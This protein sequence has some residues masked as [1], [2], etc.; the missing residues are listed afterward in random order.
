MNVPGY[1]ASTPLGLV[2]GV[3]WFRREIYLPAKIAGKRAML[4]LGRIVDA[5]SVF[6]NGTFVGTTG[7]QYP[8]RRYNIP[9]NLLKESKNTISV[10]IISNSGVGGFVPDKLYAIVCE[11]DTV[12]LAGKWQYKLGAEMEPLGGQTFVRWKPVGLYNA[13]IAPLLNFNIKGVLWYQGESNA[14]KPLEYRKL[15]PTLITDW[16]TH[17][18]QGNFPFIIVQL[19]NF[20]E[21]KNLPAESNWALFRESQLKALSVSNTGLVVAIDLGEWND[22]HPLK[23]KD[24]G[25]RLALQTE[26]LACGDKKVVSSGPIYSSMKVSGNRIVLTFNSIGSGLVAK[27]GDKLKYFAIAGP[28]KK[29]VWA[30]AE[31]QQDKVIVWSNE[32]S[33]PVAERYAWADDPDGANLY[34]KDGLPSSPFRTDEW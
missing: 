9:K 13:M 10:R 29:F 6:I 3:V 31:I 5:D 19:P 2:N 7:Y 34:N 16:R 26:K 20:M 4:I 11:G 1:W 27:N 24:I 14:E 21:Q 33:N 25:I 28:D 32:I 15:L 30:E 12:D 23:K 22:I 8:P 18:K 17:W